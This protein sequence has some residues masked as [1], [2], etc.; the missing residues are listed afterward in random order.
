MNRVFFASRGVFARLF[1]R[2]FCAGAYTPQIPVA[3]AAPFFSPV[4]ANA[5]SERRRPHAVWSVNA[6]TG[7]IECRWTTDGDEIAEWLCRPLIERAG[8]ILAATQPSLGTG[9]FR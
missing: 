3:V 5:P 7:R 1:A 9:S 6:D 4:H 2:L 8:L